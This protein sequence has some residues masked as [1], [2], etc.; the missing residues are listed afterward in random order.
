MEKNWYTGQDPDRY[1]RL[2][3]RL[4]KGVLLVGPPGTGKT[5]L[6]RA[7]AGEA[8]VPFFHA[9]GSEFDE[10][11]VG[12]GARRIRQ[13]FSSAKAKSPC[14]I[15]I[16]EIDSVG[17]KRTNSQLHPYANQTINQLLAEMDGFEKNEGIIVLAATNRKDHLD[18]ALMRPGRFDVEVGVMPPDAAGRKSIFD[19]YLSRVICDRRID[20]Y[21]L[22]LG[23]TGFTG[24][25]IENMVNQASLRAAQLNA[26]VVNL[27]HLDWAKDK[28]LMGPE[29]LGRLIDRET[30]ETTAVHEAGH[31]IVNFFNRSTNPLHK[32]TII[33]RGQALGFTSSVPEKDFYNKTRIQ[34]LAEMDVCMGG[35]VAEEVVFG[36]DKVSTGAASDFSRATQIA[37]AMVKRLGMS[38]KVGLRVFKDE[39]TDVGLA[40]VSWNEVSP[41]MQ[42]V[43]DN[44]IRRLLQESYDRAKVLIKSKIIELKAI[45][46]ALLEH[47]TLN[48]DDVKE[49]IDNVN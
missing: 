9:S 30:N 5:L 8:G 33:P 19:L 39:E 49:I 40:T 34:L 18:S 43:I 20:T 31:T 29:R 3:A 24:A 15:F 11:F 46:H 36:P 21:K 2:G 16:D 13:L 22:A 4:P 45:A 23:T 32:V 41:A 1:T 28:I 27:S 6:A 7:V 12:T 44:E 42:E 37:T 35:R 17:A 25:D 48:A 10:M 14:V 26:A 47:E 38:D